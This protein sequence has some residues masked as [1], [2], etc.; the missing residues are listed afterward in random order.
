MQKFG[1]ISLIFM[2]TLSAI[3]SWAFDGSR[4]T[5]ETGTPPPANSAAVRLYHNGE[6][7]WLSLTPDQEQQ[8]RTL[9]DAM[10]FAEATK[11]T[12]PR[13]GLEEYKRAGRAV[14]ILF[15][16]TRLVRFNGLQ[17]TS[18]DRC[19]IPLDQ[20]FDPGPARL[21]V[22]YGSSQGYS[23]TPALVQADQPTVFVLSALR[24][25]G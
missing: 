17:T 21:T 1:G 19:F 13:K 9:A 22:F 4:G 5:R 14:E 8:C 7:K 25:R 18:Y 3:L 16:T 10:T 23:P 15:P 12:G 6:I 20:P 24:N 11:I 2:F